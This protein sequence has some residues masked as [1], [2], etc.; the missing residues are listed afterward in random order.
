MDKL[1]V[2]RKEMGLTTREM[3]EEIGVSPSLYNMIE[4][5]RRNPSFSFLQKFKKGFRIRSLMSC[6]FNKKKNSS[7]SRVLPRNF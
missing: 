5:G 1:K 4:K 3:A 2:L 6:S 7:V